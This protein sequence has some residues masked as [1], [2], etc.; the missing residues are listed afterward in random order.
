MTDKIK[1]LI[2]DID[3]HIGTNSIVKLDVSLLGTKLLKRAREILMEDGSEKE[4]F[5]APEEVATMDFMETS[6]EGYKE[7]KKPEPYIEDDPKGRNVY[8]Y[9]AAQRFDLT[10]VIMDGIIQLENKICNYADY[11][12]V[13]K[14]IAD[15]AGKDLNAISITALSYLGKENG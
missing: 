2:K 5:V 1:D 6:T 7:P 4:T 13:K 14:L 11:M 12:Y 3:S 8:H 15:E 10:S 9:C